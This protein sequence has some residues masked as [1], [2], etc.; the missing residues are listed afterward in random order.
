MTKM[1]GATFWNNFSQTHLDT[2]VAS[3]EA[4]VAVCCPP[5]SFYVF[6][7]CLRLVSPAAGGQC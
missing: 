7:Y 1:G 6:S 3:H 2:L 5:D 4:Q